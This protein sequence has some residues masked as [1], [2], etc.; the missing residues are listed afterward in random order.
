MTKMLIAVNIRRG[1]PGVSGG[2]MAA[3]S[4]QMEKNAF[5]ADQASRHRTEFSG[6]I[7]DGNR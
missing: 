7:A 1:F 5:N 3:L 6:R 4:V 2:A